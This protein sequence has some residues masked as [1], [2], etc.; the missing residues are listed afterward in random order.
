MADVVQVQT[1][2]ATVVVATAQ[3]DTWAYHG[4]DTAAW[5]AQETCCTV[6]ASILLDVHSKQS[7]RQFCNSSRQA[8]AR[9]TL[10][11]FAICWA[12]KSLLLHLAMH[13]CHYATVIVSVTDELL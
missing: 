12:M 2:L 1:T 13:V 6:S 3:H 5:Y 4:L 10:C 11:F 8:V 9:A 7:Y